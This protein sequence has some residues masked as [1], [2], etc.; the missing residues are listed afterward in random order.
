MPYAPGPLLLQSQDNVGISTTD[1]KF[2]ADVANQLGEL[3][4]IPAGWDSFLEDATLLMAE[5]AD[6]YPDVDLDAAM[7]TLNA[8]S[9]AD[10]LLGIEG[11]VK[12]LGAADIALGSAISFA[13]AEAW[14]DSGLPFVAPT[15]VDPIGVPVIPPGDLVFAVTGTVAPPATTTTAPTTGTVQTPPGGVSGG[16]G[17]PTVGP[18]IN[19]TTVTLLNTSQYGN[20]NFRVGDEFQVTVLG[21][22]GQPVYVN[23]VHDYVSA[24]SAFEGNIGP[25]GRLVI[26]GTM[27]YGS[28]GYWNEQW[29]VGGVLIQS[30]DFNVASY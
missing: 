7:Q 8:Y 29:Y 5:P 16:G 1:Y 12:A 6:P 21:A 10:S 23:G 3:D 25:D 11:I 4:T 24:G 27:D 22:A 2:A 9:Y 17:A 15:A 26:T 30:F 18:I 20:P 14:Q 19:T 28:V 13:P